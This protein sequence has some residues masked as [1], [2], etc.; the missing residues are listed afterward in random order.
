MR[1]KPVQPG[2]VGPVKEVPAGIVRPDYVMGSLPVTSSAYQIN[3]GESLDRLRVAC[4][5][6][7]EVLEAV[8]REV[9]PGVTT[10]FL[11]QVAHEA[12]VG[13]GAYRRP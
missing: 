11:D 9:R 2:N 7:A 10:D 6:A 5:V 3:S 8:G 1:L 13:R 4:R 12:Y